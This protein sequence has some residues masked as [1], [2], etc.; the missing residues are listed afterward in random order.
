MNIIGQGIAFA[1][2]IAGTVALEL[3]GKKTD[4]LWMLVVVWA[5]FAEWNP[6]KKTKEDQ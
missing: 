4:G 5:V 1:A 6:K 2:L 3:N